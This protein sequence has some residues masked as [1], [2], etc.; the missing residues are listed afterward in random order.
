MVNHILASIS[1]QRRRSETAAT[2]CAQVRMSFG[3]VAE[4]RCDGDADRRRSVRDKA[5]ITGLPEKVLKTIEDEIAASP[6]SACRSWGGPSRRLGE[7]ERKRV[8]AAWPRTEPSIFF[9]C[10]FAF[11]SPRMGAEV[12]SYRLSVF[13]R[14]PSVSRFVGRFKRRRKFPIAEVAARVLRTDD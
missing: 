4:W 5:P 13:R 6:H 11:Y 9:T 10:R 3:R 14:R 1:D 7:V 2:D 8:G 12:V